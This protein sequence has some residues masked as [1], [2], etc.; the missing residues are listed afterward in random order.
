MTIKHKFLATFVAAILA[1][2]PVSAVFAEGETTTTTDATT[3]TTVTSDTYGNTTTTTQV[4]PFEQQVLQVKAV[5][6]KLLDN[7]TDTALK[8][9]L[10]KLITSKK[11]I[12][13]LAQAI[14]S[15]KKDAV[16]DFKKTKDSKTY[17]KRIHRINELARMLKKEIVKRENEIKKEQKK[18]K[19]E[20]AQLKAQEKKLKQELKAKAKAEK[21]KR[22]IAELQ[23]KIKKLEAELA[24]ATSAL[25]QTAQATT[26]VNASITQ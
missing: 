2:G 9:E 17:V 5:L 7:P 3:Q 23:A 6:V 25:N 21:A 13:V 19:R 4:N 11:D 10:N 26:T 18:D 14:N 22:K 24:A 20:L 1:L 16:A 12:R 8:A 15:L